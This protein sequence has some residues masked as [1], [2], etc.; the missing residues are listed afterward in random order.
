MVGRMIFGLVVL[1]AAI[2]L[3]RLS[4]HRQSE[5]AMAPA[6]GPA[7][8]VGAAPVE[9]AA[10]SAARVPGP[11]PDEMRAALAASRWSEIESRMTEQPASAAASPFYRAWSAEWLDALDQPEV[12]RTRYEAVCAVFSQALA[13]VG[14]QPMVWPVPAGAFAPEEQADVL[15]ASLYGA[16]RQWLER[17]N[18][19]AARHAAEASALA[20]GAVLTAQWLQTFRATPD[21][22]GP[23]L[24]AELADTCRLLRSRLAELASAGAPPRAADLQ[25][26]AVLLSKMQVQEDELWALF[27]H[28]I[29]GLKLRWNDPALHELHG[30]YYVVVNVFNN[31]YG[32]RVR[33]WRTGDGPGT[34]MKF[35]ELA[36][37]AFPDPSRRAEREPRS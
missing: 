13:E 34:V 25:E 20:T 6:P 37:R 31:R 9:P 18:Q 7:A 2:G 12:A 17:M 10:E 19:T 11:T 32:K 28:T 15:C 23:T 29:S 26:L 14:S 30:Q 24:A 16:G 5:I 4:H 1:L 27:Y 3:F 36:E 35:L 22:R 33:P 21:H 8:D